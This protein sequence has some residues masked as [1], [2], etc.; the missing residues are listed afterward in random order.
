MVGQGVRA[1]GSFQVFGGLLSGGGLARIFA[2]DGEW[3][4][5][6]GHSL[7]P[8][9]FVVLTRLGS[10]SAV[11]GNAENGRGVRRVDERHQRSKKHLGVGSVASGV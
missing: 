10:R 6:L 7:G 5:N 11:S 2:F 9:V 1:D 3:A 4:Y 8:S